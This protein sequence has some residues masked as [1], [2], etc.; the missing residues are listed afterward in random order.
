MKLSIVAGLVLVGG[1]MALGQAHADSVNLALFA[2]PGTSFVSGHET[3]GAI[4][5]G[6]EP[7]GVGDHS[8]GCYGNWPQS[9]TQWVE[10]AWKQPVSTCKVEVYWWDDGRGVRL[11]K[12]CRLLFWDGKNFVPV[13]KAEGLGVAGGRYNPTTFDEVTTSKLRLEM[14]GREKFSTGLI[15][16]KVAD[17]GKSPKFAPCVTAGPDRVVVL[18]AKTYLTGE[19]RGASEVV[20]WSKAAGPGAVAFANANA[21]MTTAAFTK[22]G[23]YVLKLSAA[24]GDLSTAATLNVRVDAAAPQQRLEPVLTHAYKINSPLWAERIKQQIVNWIPHCIAKLSEAGLKEGGFENFVEAANK[25]AG[26]PHKPHVG[27]PWANAYTHNP[28]EAMCLALMEDAQGDAELLKAQQEIRAKLDE[29]I[30]VILAAQEADGYLQTRFT[31]GTAGEQKKDKAPP[32]W[33]YVGDHEG[34]TAGYFIDSAVAHFQMTEGKDRRMYDA[35]KKIADC[36]DANIGPAPKKKWYD[37]HQA[38]E[39][40][41]VRL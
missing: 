20:V 34:Y 26:R 3:L 5:D 18:P 14:D 21:I 12:A 29:W 27:P 41:L 24:N 25:N 11:P 2:T 15:E 32:R 10:L 22:P 8:H 28:D 23:D 38:I 30:P 35:A 17:S 40:A 9:G 39:M 16:W 7:R 4:N 36:W 6:F 13:K 31:L 37:G 33:T 19:T 1:F